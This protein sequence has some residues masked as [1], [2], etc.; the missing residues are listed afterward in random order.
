[1][2]R[3]R[4]KRMI[5]TMDSSFLVLLRVVLMAGMADSLLREQ[6]RERSR[7]R[8][9]AFG[10]G[11]GITGEWR[12]RVGGR[13]REWSTFGSP[14]PSSACKIERLALAL[15]HASGFPRWLKAIS[16]E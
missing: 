16:A 4:P 8:H 14:R 9:G 5:P 7:G 13:R 11:E 12:S 10:G 15:A 2:V 6:S 3:P 1:M